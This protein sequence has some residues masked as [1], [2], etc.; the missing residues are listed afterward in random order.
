MEEQAASSPFSC[1]QIGPLSDHPHVAA[2]KDVECPG[3]A[4]VSELL[5]SLHAVGGSSASN[6]RRQG[7]YSR[8]YPLAQE[9]ADDGQG[10]HASR[11]PN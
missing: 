11:G 3:E 4:L 10:G 6:C 7:R 2:V 5:A 1:W 9:H 8:A